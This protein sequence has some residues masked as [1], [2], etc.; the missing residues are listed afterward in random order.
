MIKNNGYVYFG[1][2]FFKSDSPYN[3]L[4]IDA[5]LDEHLRVHEG[6]IEFAINGTFFNSDRQYR[7]PKI[8]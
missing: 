4:A 8:P 7:I 1:D 3:T 5:S 2:T 6:R